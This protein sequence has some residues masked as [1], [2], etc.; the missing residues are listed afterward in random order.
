[1]SGELKKAGVMGWPVAHSLSPAL[2]SYWLD[3]YKINGTYEL[4]PL[5]AHRLG[6]AI[7]TLGRRG[8][9][10]ANVTVPHKE[11]AAKAVGKLDA[12]AEVLG[13]VNLIIV[14]DDESLEG[15]NT[16]GF[17]FVENLKAGAPGIDLKDTPVCLLGAGGTTKAVAYALL[18]EG[19]RLC[20]S[21]RTQSKAEAVRDQL[22]SHI[23]GEVQIVPWAERSQ[24]L[25]GVKILVNTTS[26]GMVGQPAL[27][28]DLSRLSTDAVVTDCVYAPLETDL[29]ARAKSHGCKTVDG[30]GMLIHQA[31]P[32]FHAWFGVDPAVDPKLRDILIQRQQELST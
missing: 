18:S 8:Y 13:A 7:Q 5:E 31:R 2:H 6:E 21:N 30:L 23:E 3:K 28:L 32:A 24:A 19:A 14:D 16:D 1:M 25:S 17:G 26:L 15:R 20:I 11:F 9:V 4:M 27:E 22:K 10:G 29:L 12:T